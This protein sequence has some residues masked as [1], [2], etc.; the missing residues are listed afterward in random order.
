MATNSWVMVFLINILTLPKT[1]QEK[2]DGMVMQAI[3]VRE[4]TKFKFFV[5][6]FSV[7]TFLA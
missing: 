7:L 3:E 6:L 2:L 4:S 5:L 1:N